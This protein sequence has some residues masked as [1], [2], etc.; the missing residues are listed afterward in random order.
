MNGFSHTGRNGLPREYPP[1]FLPDALASLPD[2]GF[3]MPMNPLCWPNETARPRNHEEPGF[4]QPGSNICLDFHGD[5]MR[6]RLVVFSDGNHHMALQETL[7]AFLL[8]F[9]EV[10]DVFY[11]TTPPRVA[12]QMLQAGCLNIGNLRLSVTPHVFISPSAV[13]DQLIAEKRMTAYRPFM[14]SRGVV[15]LVR[16][17]N[18]KNIS[19]L[20]DLLRED[21]R[22]FLS[23]PV[24]EKVSYQIYTDCLRRLALHEKISLDSLANPP[25]YP[26]SPNLI[27]G[28]TIHHREAP[29][30]LMDGRADVA[31]VFYHLALRY[32][33]I[34]P[35]LFDS[36]WPTGS[37]GNQHCDINRF[38]FGLVGDG[39]P[40]GSK[41]DTFL[42]TDEVTSIYAAH[43]LERA[44]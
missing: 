22:V 43:G 25:A 35:E 37:R 8:K 7:R 19:G 18:P 1:A 41:L 2:N 3:D 16:K 29:Q 15:L 6:A 10:E 31:V 30:A 5:P 42:M 12:L 33:R 32:Q 28:D 13:L 11:V 21:V 39:G 26:G 20:R 36:V 38:G 40:W 14:H 27:Y 34:F 24:N 9:P 23:N 4:S 17:G 44:V